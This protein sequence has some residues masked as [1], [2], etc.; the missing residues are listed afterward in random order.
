MIKEVFKGRGGVGIS[1]VDTII[2][3]GVSGAVI[4]LIAL[5]VVIT[6]LVLKR[7]KKDNKRI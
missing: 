3:V 4:F 1:S 7:K 2:V 6:W 5:V